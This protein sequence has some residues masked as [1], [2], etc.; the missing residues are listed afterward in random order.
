MKQVAVAG[1]NSTPA[2]WKGSGNCCGTVSLELVLA[3][4]VTVRKGPGDRL[5]LKTGTPGEF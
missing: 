1:V 3:E 4:G 5:S 2:L